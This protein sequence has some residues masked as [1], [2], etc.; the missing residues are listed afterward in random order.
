[1]AIYTYKC[2]T[3]QKVIEALVQGSEKEQYCVCAGKWVD[4]MVAT[5]MQ[6]VLSVPSPM[7]WGCQKGF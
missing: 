6:K 4:G 7:Q 2:P 1:M 5:K 3:C